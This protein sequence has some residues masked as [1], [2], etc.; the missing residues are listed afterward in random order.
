MTRKTAYI[1]GGAT[2]FLL[3]VIALAWGDDDELPTDASFICVRTGETYDLDIAD[4]G[5]IPAKNPDTGQRTLLPCDWDDKGKLRVDG[6][7]RAV[8]EGR[9]AGINHWVDPQTLLIRST[10]D[11][12]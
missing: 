11:G 10:R 3:M 8:L 12:G 7:Y 1:A 4:V 9:L 2:V 5:I 6:H